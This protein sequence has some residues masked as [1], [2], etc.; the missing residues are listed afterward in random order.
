[1]SASLRSSVFELRR[2]KTGTPAR[3]NGRTIDFSRCE[4]VHPGDDQPEPFSAPPNPSVS[5]RS[6]ATSHPPHLKFTRSFAQI[7]IAHLCTQARSSP[8]VLATAHPSKTKLSDSPNEKPTRCSRNPRSQHLR[9]LL[10]RNFRQPASRCSGSDHP[11]YSGCE[12]AEIMRYGYAVEYDFAPPTQLF[13]TLETR[14]V[15]GLFFAGQINGTTG[16][17]GCRTG[18]DRRHSMPA[19]PSSG[20]GRICP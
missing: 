15:Q 14:S 17:E 7:C 18:T 13:P 2:F 5:R 1:M 20:T 8:P 10:Q 11:P 12:K 3:L 16:Y 4:K 9:N 6:T 19:A